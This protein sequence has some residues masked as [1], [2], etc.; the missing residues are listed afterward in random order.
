[1]WNAVENMMFRRVLKLK[2]N[3]FDS[4]GPI[5]RFCQFE[6]SFYSSRRARHLVAVWYQ[7]KSFFYAS[8]CNK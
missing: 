4:A 8:E 3:A 1:M 5:D 2:T 6:L 7:P